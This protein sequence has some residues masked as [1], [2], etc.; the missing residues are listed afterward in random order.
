M[1]PQCIWPLTSRHSTCRKPIF[2][3]HSCC[4]RGDVSPAPVMF[5]MYL[6]ARSSTCVGRGEGVDVTN[7]THP[8]CSLAYGQV[9]QG[10]ASGNNAPWYAAATTLVFTEVFRVQIDVGY[11]LG[12]T[13]KCFWPHFLIQSWL[14]QTF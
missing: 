6:G 4:F 7:F 1:G 12:T 11:I 9:K 10:C 3:H 13:S 14:L 5:Q 8:S 2:D